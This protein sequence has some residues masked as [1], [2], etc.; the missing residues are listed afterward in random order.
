MIADA[1]LPP[2]SVASLIDHTL[3][4]PEASEE[5]IA[6]LCAE[7]RQFAF[8]S[9][10]VNPFWVPFAVRALEGAA[11]VCS[12]VGFPLGAND[13]RTKLAEAELALS[14]GAAELDMVINIGA[15]R[16]HQYQIAAKEIGDLAELAHSQSAILKV[17][18]ETCLL[19]DEEKI[20]A[21]RLAVEASADFVKTSTGF[22][23]SGATVEDVKLM[24]QCVGERV[25]VKASGGIRSL[26][27]LRL[28]LGAG[29]NRI[30]TSSGVQIM[31]E[32]KGEPEQKQPIPLSG[33][34]VP[35]GT[36]EGY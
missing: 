3:L 33:A 11:K 18:L 5:E 27:A 12:T 20:T 29:A 13:A 23:K 9:V 34:K 31:N 2:L 22:S 16:S 10:C 17:I 25:G 6:R 28:M 4:K 30:G 32:L 35:G 1:N 15:L 7:A 19:T 14:H 36:L 24:R 26:E 21:C 8:A